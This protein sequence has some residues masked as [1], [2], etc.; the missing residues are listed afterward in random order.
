[1]LLSVAITEQLPYNLQQR[2][3]QYGEFS[4]VVQL[5]VVLYL[6]HRAPYDIALKWWNI[7]AS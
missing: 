5:N 4:N 1:M 3:S 6:Q 2:W 7:I